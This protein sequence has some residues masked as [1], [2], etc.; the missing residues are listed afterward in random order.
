MHYFN[1]F[2]FLSAIL[3][4]FS[5][6]PLPAQ[7]SMKNSFS[8][9][10]YLQIKVKENDVFLGVKEPENWVGDL[11]RAPDYYST[12]MFYQNTKSFRTGGALIRVLVYTK[13][14]EN[15][16]ADLEFDMNKFKKDNR[17]AKYSEMEVTHSDYAVFGKLEYVEGK[18]YEYITYLNPGREFQ[19]GVLVR[20]ELKNRPAN[21]SEWSIYEE[22]VRSVHLSPI[23]KEEEYKNKGNN[24]FRK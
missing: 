21:K 15:T 18:N 23:E 22:I 20:M 11:V 5:V 9:G 24:P 6:S 19:S 16:L 12:A 14:D 17:K 13:T 8:G 3:V 1:Q 2:I 4:L 7:L 10:E